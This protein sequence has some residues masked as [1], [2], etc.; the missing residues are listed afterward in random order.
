MLKRAA[1]KEGAIEG[2]LKETHFTTSLGSYA[3]MTVLR[4]S[5][6]HR[7]TPPESHRSENRGPEST[8]KCTVLYALH[9]H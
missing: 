3:P 8:G 5:E 2:A 9:N 1:K 7:Q 6:E 4:K